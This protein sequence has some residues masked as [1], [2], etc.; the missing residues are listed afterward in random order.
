MGQIRLLEDMANSGELI[1]KKAKNLGFGEIEKINIRQ[2]GIILVEDANNYSEKAL[3]LLQK[4]NPTILSRNEPS[5]NVK[6]LLQS[7]GVTAIPANGIILMETQKHAAADRKKLAE[8]IKKLA[9]QNVLNIIETYKE[10][11]KT[12]I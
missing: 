7:A 2:G 1:A 8:A 3:E 11:R 5:P 10:K 9:A 4:S 6:R 12:L